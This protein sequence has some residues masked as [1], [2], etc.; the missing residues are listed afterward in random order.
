MTPPRSHS[1]GPARIS[2]RA[3]GIGAGA[4]VVGGAVFASRWFNVTADAGA[5]GNLRVED[6]H[7]A[8]LSGAV[9]LIDI[10]RPDEWQRTGVGEGAIA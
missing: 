4:F 1:E 10:R 5:Q 3:F 2:R 6:A 7:A 8:A 9:L